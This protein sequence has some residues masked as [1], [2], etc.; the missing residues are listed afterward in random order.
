LGP[1]VLSGSLTA[2]PGAARSTT[3]HFHD[4]RQRP[5]AATV[6]RSR[7]SN[8]ILRVMP[9]PS[10]S[11]AERGRL[12]VIAAPSGA[13][14]TS[15]VNALLGRR[16]ALRLSVSHTTRKK[17]PTETE[18]REY[19]FVSLEEFNRLV[20]HREFL[21]HAQVFDN[22]YGTS[23]QFVEEQLRDGRSVVLEID[24]QG[25][26]QVRRAMPD[27]VTIFVLPP[28]RRALEERLRKRATDAEEVIERRLRDAVSDMAHWQ[29][30]DYVVVNDDFD[31]A[32]SDLE[33][34]VEGRAQDLQKTRTPLRSLLADL[35]A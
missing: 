25:A 35:L 31:R 24:W 16:P 13:G 28:S 14:K 8:H 20:G 18:G 2:L 19:H 5:A 29:E 33:R 7:P 22:H 21:E 15:L 6:Y 3:S 1:E 23:R 27:C 30:F 34:I 11:S 26:Q 4:G 32:V 17:R 12:F 9:A 10:T